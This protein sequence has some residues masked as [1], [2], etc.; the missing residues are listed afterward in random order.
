[1][2]T[3]TSTTLSVNGFH[4]SGCSDNLSKAI[5]NL[6]GVIRGRVSRHE[7]LGDGRTRQ[8]LRRSATLSV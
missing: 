2:A 5:A 1:M 6:D 8:L 3:T 4:C 7:L